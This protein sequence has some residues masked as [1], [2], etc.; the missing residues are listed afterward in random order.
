MSAVDT[1]PLPLRPTTGPARRWAARTVAVTG[2]AFVAVVI[3]QA[4]VRDGFS[5]ADHPLS[6]LAL[7]P[8]G[9]VQI[10]AFVVAG[11][12]FAAAGLAVSRTAL[13]RASLWPARLIGVFGICLLLSGVFPADPANGYPA[14]AD[15]AA[16]WVGAVHS[17]A[18]GIGG[19]ALVAV[20]TVAARRHVRS[21]ERRAGVVAGVVAA[22]SLILGAA[23]S[24]T[25]DFRIAFVG[26]AIAWVWASIY[27]A[28]QLV[29]GPAD[30]QQPH[31][32]RA[33]A[34]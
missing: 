1:R 27:L 20:A 12:V 11:A 8:G 5:L 3:V 24:G 32:E 28:D 21:G 7:G 30:S 9:S 33:E 25:G 16:T 4:A 15:D 23:G 29:P 6:L 22:S 2:P 14:G 31:A 19:L 26:G 10:A 13:P 34:L 18:A 17:A